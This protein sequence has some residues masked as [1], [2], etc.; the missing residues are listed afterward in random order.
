M[1][2][3]IAQYAI[4]SRLSCDLARTPR[5]SQIR[6]MVGFVA[7]IM[8][9][10]VDAREFATIFDRTRPFV[11]PM[12]PAEGLFLDRCY[13][14]RYNLKLD[15]TKQSQP[16]MDDINHIAWDALDAPVEQFKRERIHPQILER[17]HAHKAYTLWLAHFL[18]RPRYWQALLGG[19]EKG[20][21][22]GGSAS[23]EERA[24]AMRAAREAEE[25]ACAAELAEEARLEAADRSGNGN[26]GGRG[27]R[28]GGGGSEDENDRQGHGQG[29]AKRAK[30]AAPASTSVSGAA[31]PAA[32]AAASTQ[33]APIDL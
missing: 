30:V 8:R 23:D 18:D 4:V 11:T 14:T 28:G 10:L 25:G 32:T 16:S 26:G 19:S 6:K 29:A 2:N 3:S 27:G 15:S 9:G 33:S 13:F 17:S 12:A 5:T 20:N 22:G 24:R 21:G 7:A 31:Q 1:E